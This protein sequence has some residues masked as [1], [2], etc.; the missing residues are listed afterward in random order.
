M[1][2]LSSSN[3]E[4]LPPIKLWLQEIRFPHG[5]TPDAKKANADVAADIV[6][7]HIARLQSENERLKETAIESEEAQALLDYIDGDSHTTPQGWF[8]TA[9]EKLRRISSGTS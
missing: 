4:E 5:R 7:K 6:E 9:Y 8:D 3:R 2:D 1:T